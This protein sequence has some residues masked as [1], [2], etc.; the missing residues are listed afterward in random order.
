MDGSQSPVLFT[1]NL[2]VASQVAYNPSDCRLL[3]EARTVQEALDELCRRSGDTGTD[4]GFHVEGVFRL[5]DDA[6]VRNGGEMWPGEWAG[7]LRIV[8]DKEVE[9]STVGPATCFGTIDLPWPLTEDE[10]SWFNTGRWAAG[11]QPLSLSS[12]LEV[13]EGE[14]FWRPVVGEDFIEVLTFMG[15]I[16]IHELLA[17]FTIKGNFIHAREDPDVYLDG[18]TFG[19][20]RNEFGI[21]LPTGD[22][23]RGGDFEIFTRLMTTHI[24]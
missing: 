19:D 11:F 13:K 20:P 1:A 24:G 10:Q 3:A 23:R 12:T 4:P 9:P 21:R 17:R 16:G 2:S 7:G 15:N 8:F 5:V 6:P 18:D 14:V 22:G